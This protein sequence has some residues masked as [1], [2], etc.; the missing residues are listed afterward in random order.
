[1]FNF[2]DILET[3]VKNTY[4]LIFM[5]ALTWIL[6]FLKPEW[7]YVWFYYS[8]PKNWLEDSTSY[9]LIGIF[10]ILTMMFCFLLGFFLV[11]QKKYKRSLFC[12]IPIVIGFFGMNYVAQTALKK[13]IHSINYKQYLMSAKLSDSE[14]KKI[15]SMLRRDCQITVLELNEDLFGIYQWNPQENQRLHLE[16][17]KATNESKKELI[18]YLQADP[19]K[20][21]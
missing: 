4:Y 8:D 17:C 7:M 18:D 19:K 1:M 16:N 10:L 5:T 12:I 6:V 11:L 13:E 9:A 3:F 20:H 14:A 21:L 15:A 2:K